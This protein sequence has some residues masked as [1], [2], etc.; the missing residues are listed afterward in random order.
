[1][2]VRS[3]T[4]IIK[5]GDVAVLSSYTFIFPDFILTC[6]KYFSDM[7]LWPDNYKRK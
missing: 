1:M 7:N 3:P 4:A 5:F 6:K 2:G